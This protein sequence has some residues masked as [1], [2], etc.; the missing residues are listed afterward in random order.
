MSELQ[1]SLV[2]LRIAA[3]LFIVEG[4]FLFIRALI[5]YSQPGSAGADGVRA[6]AVVDVLSAPL[7]ICIGIGIL[8]RRKIW[9]ALGAILVGLA[10][11]YEL[12]V[13]LLTYQPLGP[14]PW[15]GVLAEALVVSALWGV[16]LWALTNVSAQQYC[17]Q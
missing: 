1:R 8:N 2:P 11:G 15:D 17:S 12:A 13:V 3:F 9:R 4:A 5:V 14:H 7:S 10:L 16:Q 6:A